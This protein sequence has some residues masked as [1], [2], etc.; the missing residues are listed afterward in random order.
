MA[1]IPRKNQDY[2]N[3]VDK[4]GFTEYYGHG[5]K[6]IHL[7]TTIDESYVLYYKT[8]HKC[9]RDYFLGIQD[10]SLVRKISAS[11]FNRYKEVYNKKIEQLKAFIDGKKFKNPV[12]GVLPHL[13]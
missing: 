7:P 10:E 1:F 6:Y 13:D 8:F 3:F 2:I 9:G 12:Q 5:Y 11:D 4:D